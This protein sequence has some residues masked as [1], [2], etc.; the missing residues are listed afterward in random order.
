MQIAETNH[1]DW[2]KYFSLCII[3]ILFYLNQPYKSVSEIIYNAH[4]KEHLKKQNQKD[5][6]RCF[7]ES[8]KSIK[9]DIFTH[10]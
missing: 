6:H 7:I 8:H 3:L 9:Q 1:L 4:L 2:N 5:S 10:F